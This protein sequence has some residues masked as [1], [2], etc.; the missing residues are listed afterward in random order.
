MYRR[1]PVDDL[2]DEGHHVV[3]LIRGDQVAG[4]GEDPHV[5]VHCP[6]DCWHKPMRRQEP[7]CSPTPTRHGRPARR[8]RDPSEGWGCQRRTA[9]RG[10]QGHPSDLSLGRLSSWGNEHPEHAP[11]VSVVGRS[12]QT[13]DASASLGSTV[14]RMKPAGETRARPVI[15]GDSAAKAERAPNELPTRTTSVDQ[16]SRGSHPALANTTPAATAAAE[17]VAESRLS[18]Q[19]DDHGRPPCGQLLKPRKDHRSVEAGPG[20]QDDPRPSSSS[21]GE[22]HAAG[23]GVHGCGGKW[24]VGSRQGVRTPLPHRVLATW[25][26]VHRGHCAS[27]CRDTEFLQPRR[28]RRHNSRNRG[29]GGTRIAH[30]LKPSRG[31]GPSGV[32]SGAEP[33]SLVGIV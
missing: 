27:M 26:P 3:Q 23:A 17:G 31:G 16:L 2:G 1:R 22:M 7:S 28:T 5:C 29:S 14:S 24:E 32:M 20:D 4:T 12:N 25:T 15:R 33:G 8:A 21:G 18:R 6:A 13:A 19:V 10:H 11:G 30:P 9:T